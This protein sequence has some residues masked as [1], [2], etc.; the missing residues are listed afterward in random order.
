MATGDKLRL[1]LSLTDA[2]KRAVKVAAAAAGQTISEWVAQQAADA[3]AG[4]PPTV[5]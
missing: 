5:Q 2:D 3:P 1:V 4:Q